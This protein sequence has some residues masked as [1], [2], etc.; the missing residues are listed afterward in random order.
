MNTY[1]E[2]YGHR[3]L[4]TMADFTIDQLMLFIGGVLGAIG[5]LLVVIQK[6]KCEEIACCC[7]KCKRNVQAII[8]EEKLAMT[9]HTGTTPRKSLAEA[10]NEA[11]EDNRRSTERH[12]SDSEEV[13]ETLFT[14]AGD[15]KLDK[16]S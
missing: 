14:S 9:G 8:E 1:G 11:R 12:E 15:L 4:T 16:K 3:M 2:K 6:S 10:N 5:A 7:L 13:G